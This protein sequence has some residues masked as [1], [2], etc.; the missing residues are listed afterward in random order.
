MK[1]LL[2]TA[3]LFLV[4]NQLQAQSFE[5]NKVQLSIDT[6]DGENRIVW[7][8]LKEIN[9]SY[10]LIYKSVDG[11]TFEQIARVNAK[12]YCGHTSQYGFIDDDINNN[13]SYKVL[14]VN[15]EGLTTS[16]AQ[17]KFLD[18]LQ[19]AELINHIAIK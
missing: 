3:A 1:N 7:Q 13:T 5:A 11:K 17:V 9:T 10:F 12:G 19:N 18:T 8:T 6:V 2:L 14:L 4:L 15:M 16:S